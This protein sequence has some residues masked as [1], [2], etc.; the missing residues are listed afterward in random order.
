ML[1]LALVILIVALPP[2]LAFTRLLWRLGEMPT[3]SKP[4]PGEAG[5]PGLPPNVQALVELESEPWAR[6][7]LREVAQGL[8]DELGSSWER[9]EV[10]LR[11]RY[12]TGR[13]A[14]EAADDAWEQA[15][16][17]IPE[18]AWT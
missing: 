18:E 11:R 16:S 9:V 14:E 2:S 10:E 13:S 12:G 7:D 17:D 3:L 15:K 5:A 1:S 8:Y 6:D 4:K